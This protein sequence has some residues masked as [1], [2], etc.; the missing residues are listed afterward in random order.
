MTF[1]NSLIRY[2]HAF[3]LTFIRL[4]HSSPITRQQ[5]FFLSYLIQS[6]FVRN[7]RTRQVKTTGLSWELA[8]QYLNSLQRI[9]YTRRNGHLWNITEAG[10][11]YYYK[12]MQEFTRN[13]QG[14]FFWK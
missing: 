1:D 7:F 6:G 10:V 9:G 12:F 2:A 8:N 11:I 14:A 3:R 13:H 4:K 5:I